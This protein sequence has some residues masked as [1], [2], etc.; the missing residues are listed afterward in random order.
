MSETLRGDSSIDSAIRDSWVENLWVLPTKPDPDAG[1]L[2]ATKFSDMMRDIGDK[3]DVIVADTPPLLG[4]DD[5][6]TLA[7]MANGV[8]LVVSSKTLVGTVSEAVL[9]LETLNAPV[10]GVI[11]NRIRESK[12]SSYYA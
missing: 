7:S 12:R 9:S 6:R 8:L 1:D 10:L 2:L 4:T 11:G 3:Y 5:A